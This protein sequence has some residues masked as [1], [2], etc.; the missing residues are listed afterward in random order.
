MGIFE[1]VYTK[2]HG[3]LPASL[4]SYVEVLQLHTK[5]VVILGTSLSLPGFRVQKT[6][7]FSKNLIILWHLQYFVQSQILEFNFTGW[8]INVFLKQIYTGMSV[9][10][11]MIYFR[12]I[13]VIYHW[14][15]LTVGLR[16][17]SVN[18]PMTPSSVVQSRSGRKGCH[19][20]RPGQAG[21]VGLCKPHSV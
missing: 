17:P 7:S 14:D 2:Y 4:A 19:L 11:S 8:V 13:L 15:W 20:E 16:A 5:R 10:D 3:I 9:W 6:V 12:L 18:S 1:T 21:E